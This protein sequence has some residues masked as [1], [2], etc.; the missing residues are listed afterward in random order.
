M[1]SEATTKNQPPDMLIIMFQIM[2]GI[3]Y[4]TS[5]FQNFC[6]AVSLRLTDTSCRSRGTVR[7][8]W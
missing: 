2:P 4:G 7:S 6:Q 3:A 8:D 1:A 5:S